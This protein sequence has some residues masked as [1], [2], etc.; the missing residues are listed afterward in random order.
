MVVGCWLWVVGLWIMSSLVWDLGVVG[1]LAVVFGE[2]VFIALR[3]QT[4]NPQPKTYNPLFPY[5]CES[6]F[7]SLVCRVVSQ[8]STPP[9]ACFGKIALLEIAV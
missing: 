1:L 8:N 5:L 9:D 2:S 7:R 6:L 3:G 4:Y